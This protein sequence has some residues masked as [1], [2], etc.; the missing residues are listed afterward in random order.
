MPRFRVV[1]DR[2]HVWIDARSTGHAVAARTDGV[3]R[4]LD[5]GPADGSRVA[6]TDPPVSHLWIRVE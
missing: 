2:S 1:P 4:F 6:A 3:Q 5:L